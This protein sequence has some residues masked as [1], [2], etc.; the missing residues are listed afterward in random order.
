MSAINETVLMI[1][2]GV[3]FCS[4]V[5]CG[6]FGAHVASIWLKN[7][8]EERRLEIK[9]RELR[10][11][12]RLQEERKNWWA[13]TQQQSQTIKELNDKV[14]ELS[15]NYEINKSLLAKAEKLKVM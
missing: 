1:A 14:L 8:R 7:R 12:D 5:L 2:V 10:N 11:E 4:V 13:L 9:M 6:S 15:R 3:I